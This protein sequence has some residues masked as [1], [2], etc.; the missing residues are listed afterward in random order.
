MAAFEDVDCEIIAGIC[1]FKIN[2]PRWRNQLLADETPTVTSTTIYCVNNIPETEQI[3]M[4]YHMAHGFGSPYTQVHARALQLAPGYFFVISSFAV[5]YLKVPQLGGLVVYLGMCKALLDHTQ[6]LVSTVAVSVSD[7][8]PVK[9]RS[10]SRL[11]AWQCVLCGLGFLFSLPFVTNEGIF[12]VKAV[13]AYMPWLCGIVL[14]SMEVAGLV[15]LYGVDNICHNFQLM[16][17]KKLVLFACIWKFL[18]LP[19][20]LAMGVWA[21]V[22]GV[23]GPVV[24]ENL[25][26]SPDREDFY[27]QVGLGV[28]LLPPALALLTTLVLL[29]L[30]RQS[31][32]RLLVPRDMW[33][34]ALVQHR[35]LYTPGIIRAKT[36]A[37]YL[38]IQVSVLTLTQYEPKEKRSKSETK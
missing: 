22:Q 32:K 6:M 2:T 16:V 1:D 34:P 19:S 14:G 28:A 10:G 24:W 7:L 18:L 4:S 9:W 5:T 36:R 29:V 13:D 35:A 26:L 15:Y 23:D 27:R 17:R 12:L 33:G 38:I 31:L 11:L 25:Q 20:F 21:C 37:P 30:A 8:L 3:L